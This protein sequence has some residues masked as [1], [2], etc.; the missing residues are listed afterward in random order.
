MFG[1]IHSDTR[2]TEVQT[3]SV[4]SG[5]DVLCDLVRGERF[6]YR[7][8]APQWESWD[9]PDARGH[10]ASGPC[11]DTAGKQQVGSVTVWTSLVSGF[12][13]PI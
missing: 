11:A 5:R 10:S 2:A 7:E 3:A 9:C 1:L 12:K 6:V 4:L 8:Q 13:S